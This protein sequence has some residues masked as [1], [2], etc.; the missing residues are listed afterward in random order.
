MEV[1]R[2]TVILNRCIRTRLLVFLNS[3]VRVGVAEFYFYFYFCS[4]RVK[5]KEEDKTMK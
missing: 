5:E 1:A 3:N 4:E 2:V